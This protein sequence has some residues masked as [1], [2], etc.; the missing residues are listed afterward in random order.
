MGKNPSANNILLEVDFPPALQKYF[1]LIL[2]SEKS[3]HAG[4]LSSWGDMG[5]LLPWEGIGES[6]GK[7]LQSYLQAKSLTPS[8]RVTPRRNIY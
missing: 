2:C 5:Q 8:S 4:H 7:S 1:Y 6:T 3:I